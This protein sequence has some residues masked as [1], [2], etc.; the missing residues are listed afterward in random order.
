MKWI[1]KQDKIIAIFLLLLFL[2]M[3]L[4]ANVSA[5]TGKIGNA[6]VVLYPEVDG[7]TVIDRTILIINDNPFP[8]EINITPSEEYKDIIQVADKD[9]TLKAGEEK[10]AKFKII[11]SQPGNYDGRLLVYFTEPEKKQGV[12]LSSRIIIYAT[13]EGINDNI[14]NPEEET[15]PITGG[16]IKESLIEK[17]S[18]VFVILGLT[19]LI[20]LAVLT[21]LIRIMNKKVEVVTNKRMKKKDE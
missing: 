17:I 18:P 5:V 20:A 21:F 11:L 8:V 4:S 13:E 12:A 2:T 6:R 10:D 15:E 9:F 1:Q 14:E 19:T 7:R 16:T 3:F